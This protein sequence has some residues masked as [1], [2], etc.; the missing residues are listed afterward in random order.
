M[1]KIKLYNGDCINVLQQLID[2]GVKVD[3]II[4]DPPYGTTACKWDTVIPF[5]KM[6]KLLNGLIRDDGAIVLF[7]SEPF[8][9]N[10]VCS[11]IENFRHSWIYK[12]RCASNF[13]Q[14][15]YAPMKEHE[16]VLVFGKKKVRYFPIM[17]ERK[18]SGKERAKYKYTDASRH[19]SGEFVGKMNGRYEEYSKELRYP[20]SVQEF[21]NRA[22]GDRGLHPTQ[23]PVSLME[24]LVKTYTNECDTVLDFTMGSGTTGVAAVNL[25]RN[26]IGIELDKTYFDIAEKRIKEA[27]SK[28]KELDKNN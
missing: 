3:A 28:S 18:G 10:L 23:K 5:D 22:S 26:F 7:G 14:A 6:W 15:S 17:E 12:K 4:T 13:A 1:G 2:T 21:N 9:S 20:S 24:Y 11:N 27:I 19:K 16:N 8:S 25:N